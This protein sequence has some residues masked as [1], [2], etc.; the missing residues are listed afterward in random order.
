MGPKRK[1]TGSLNATPKKG[2]K[3]VDSG[4]QSTLDA[5]L[6]IKSLVS[7]GG[8][9]R[10]GSVTSQ[11]SAE[12][13]EN[14]EKIPAAVLAGDQF[15]QWEE[16]PPETWATNAK[17]RKGF[18]SVR[19]VAGPELVPGP[20]VETSAVSISVQPVDEPVL[21]INECVET[22]PPYWQS[23][24]TPY[25][26]L[27]ERF[28]A[29]S[30]VT[31]R[32][33]ITEK[34]T[35]M[36]RLI[37][38]HAPQDLLPALYLSSNN[39]APAYE[40][41]ELGIGPQILV[42]AITSISDMSSKTIKAT[43]D[44]KG[45]WGDVVVAARMSTQMLVQPKPLTVA[46]VFSTLQ[47]I[48][49]MKGQGTVNQKADLV[50]KMMIACQGE[51]LRFLTRTLVSHLRIGAVRTTILI[52]LSHAVL[53]EHDIPADVLKSLSKDQLKA[54]VKTAEQTLKECY[55]QVP[56]YDIIVPLL[57][58][59]DIGLARIIAECKCM[60]GVP[61]R[62]MLGKITRDLTEVFE[63]LEGMNFCADYKYDGQ[64]AQIHRSDSGEITIFSRHLET[65]TDKYPDIIT[66]IP[67]IITPST[68]S[69][70]L[71]A[72]VVAID[73]AGAVASFQTLSN[74]ARKNVAEGEVK[75]KVCVYAFDL[76]FLNGVSLITESFRT[77]RD[78]MR[79][80]FVPV[81]K[82]FAF[83]EQLESKEPDEIQAFLTQSLQNGC[84]GIMVKILDTPSTT[85]T[86]TR[87]SLLATYEP[88]K[89]TESWLK[90]KKDYLSTLADSFDLVP[91]GAWY[92]TG[93]KATWYSPILLACW[94]PETE[95]FE[96]F[97]KCMS[98]FSDAFYKSM[99]DRYSPESGK[100]LPGPKSYFTI[101][102]SQRPDVWFL[103][104]EVW[105]IRGADLTVSPVHQAAMG[106]VDEA[107]GIS[108]RFP[109][110]IKVR[111]DRSVEDATTPDEIV[112]MF[113]RQRVRGPEPVKEA[114]EE[115]MG[116]DNEVEDDEII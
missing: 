59:P 8:N 6:G 35:H 94:N 28:A 96:S 10:D 116:G 26:L 80:A 109:R 27:A 45:D 18:D 40:G 36:L 21:P 95:C 16:W 24:P 88:D 13:D 75:V 51:E 108:L 113:T 48:A 65:M 54:R 4:T 69:F 43:W 15:E 38:R 57:L 103:P 71:D 3:D 74:R 107:K 62:P 84:E 79:K 91:I 90:V 81:E 37:I 22:R 82:R 1:S 23:G 102:D 72:E 68:T 41:I 110:F 64:R 60:P 25:R 31:G 112:H 114:A 30:E 2:K 106:K 67:S 100:L 89:R 39:I 61:I 47:K 92:G 83:V 105:E 58:N 104:S 55:A 78:A 97:C 93:R 42:K 56:N 49:A 12:R 11:T 111:D 85:S 66:L 14:G 101:S 63:N 77:R 46:G 73:E 87:R 5:F 17:P 86:S 50:K 20:V 34:L 33:V 32:Q 98:G 52:A 76:M 115:D 99:K 44:V 19:D 29:V 70:I 53:L 7:P 9:K